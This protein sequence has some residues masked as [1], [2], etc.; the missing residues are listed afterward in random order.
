M[1]TTPIFD[2]WKDFLY[3]APHIRAFP[4]I[5]QETMRGVFYSGAATC[6]EIIAIAL[7]EQG[8]PQPAICK[9]IVAELMATEFK[10][11]VT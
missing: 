5:M 6:G 9:T 4:E 10:E 11:S 1:S 8:I 7:A 3:E 2:G